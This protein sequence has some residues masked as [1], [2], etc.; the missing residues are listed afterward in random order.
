MIM[1][2]PWKESRYRTRHCQLWYIMIVV[3]LK[4]RKKIIDVIKG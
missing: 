4:F 3:F 2:A 1:A